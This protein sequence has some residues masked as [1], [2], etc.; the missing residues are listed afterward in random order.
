MRWII[1]A[2]LFLSTLLN[3][4]D[5]Q[6]VAVLKPELSAE[7]DLSNA[8][9]SLLTTMFMAPY[10]VMYLVGGRMVDRWGSRTCMML[11][12]GVW[13]LA[14]LA[15]GLV[16]NVWQLCATRF[17]LGLAEPGNMPAA[18]RAV[19][20]WFPSRERGLAVA[21]F[22]AGSALGA[23]IAPP[24]IALVA[25]AYGWRA[26]FVILGAAGL[27]WLALWML[28]YREP[29]VQTVDA[30]EPASVRALLSNRGVRGILVARLISDPVWYVL[31]FWLPSFLREQQGLSLASLGVIGWIPF[32]AAD[33]GGIGGSSAA[34]ALIRR[35]AD[36]VAS[37]MRVLRWAAAL[38]PLCLALILP[39]STPV[40]LAI[41]SAVGAMCLTW[42]FGTAALLGELLP[43]R[44]V[45]GA[46]GLVGAA[47]ALGGLIVNAAVGPAIDAIGFGPTLAVLAVLHPIAALRLRRSLQAANA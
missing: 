31:L 43:P 35:G 16:R 17:M 39:V 28:I 6:T 7:F 10:I 36:P 42:F 14:T 27:V 45:A 44:Q 19:T 47:G 20:L 30:G 2:L 24:T 22:S 12:V 40:A 34:D 1:L 8:D 46:L 37:R 9:Y 33:I 15:G 13:S 5:R 23:I 29:T 26:V 38:G 11:F 21:I 4:L 3:Y 25:A 32:L 18:L 41:F